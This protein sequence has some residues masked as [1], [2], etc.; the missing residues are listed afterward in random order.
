MAG[1]EVT[2]GFGVDIS[3]VEVM[4]N[5]GRGI[6]IDGGLR[7]TVMRANHTVS[8]GTIHDFAKVMWCYHPG[9][10]VARVGCTVSNNEIYR[11]P[12][13]GIL[14]NGNDHLIQFNVFHDLLLESFDSGAIY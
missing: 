5:G 1:I 10:H 3:D 14:V 6:F 12:H 11:A 4:Y 9:I 2:G 13:Q 8:N 7:P